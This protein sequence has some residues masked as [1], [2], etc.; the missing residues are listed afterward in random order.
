MI[1]TVIGALIGLKSGG[2]TGL[3]MGAVLGY[4]VQSW[5][6]RGG[7]P[8]GSKAEIQQSYFDALFLTLGKIAKADGQV[9]DVEIQRAEAI[10]QHMRLSA[11]MRKQ[12]IALFNRGKRADCDIDPVLAQ[13]ARLSRGSLSLRRIFLEMLLDVAEADGMLSANE[14]HIIDRV[15]VQ[16]GY[17]REILIVMLKM[18]GFSRAHSQHGGGQQQQRQYTRSTT[19]AA[20]NPYTLLGVNRGDGKSV[21]RRAYKKLMSQHHPDK[22]IAKGLPPEMIRVAEEKAKKIQRAYEQIKNERNF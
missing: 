17:P 5:F 4:V 12:A 19:A 6:T 18:R 8:T 11:T 16:L 14:W 2:F 10:F 9:K 13:F 7:V 3:L 15:C 21:I 22:L 1:G 20:E